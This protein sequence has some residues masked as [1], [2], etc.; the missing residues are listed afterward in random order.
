VRS[1]VIAEILARQSASF[2]S[3][4]VERL[5]SSER[6]RVLSDLSY[7]LIPRNLQVSLDRLGVFMPETVALGA[8][9]QHPALSLSQI[10]GSHN[11][12]RMAGVKLLLLGRSTAIMFAQMIEVPR[13][14]FP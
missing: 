9:C 1:G 3:F 4:V 13:L 7:L 8:H 12:C 14:R 5:N 2:E 6:A 11:E 10:V